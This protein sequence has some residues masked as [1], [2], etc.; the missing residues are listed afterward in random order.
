[1]SSLVIILSLYYFI[2][3]ILNCNLMSS[4]PQQK[5]SKANS[6]QPEQKNQVI[7]K[8]PSLQKSDEELK[9]GIVG[10]E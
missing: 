9:E 4:P 5:D 1:M 8:S 7:L 2:I 6:V 10:K 3:N